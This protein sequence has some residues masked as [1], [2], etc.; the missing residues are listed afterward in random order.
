MAFAKPVPV[1]TSTAAALF[2]SIEVPFWFLALKPTMAHLATVPA[3]TLRYFF[4]FFDSHGFANF[5]PLP[6]IGV[7]V[8]SGLRTCC[9]ID[10]YRLQNRRP[11][12]ESAFASVVKIPSYMQPW[13]ILEKD[14]P[15]AMLHAKFWDK[16][17]VVEEQRWL[18]AQQASPA[19]GSEYGLRD[20]EGEERMDAVDNETMDEATTMDPEDDIISGCYMLDIDI[21][22]LEL[23]SLWIRAEYIRVFN[24]VNAY[25]D[26]PTS[27]RRAPCVVVTGQ[28]GIG[29]SVWVY[30]ALRRCLAERKPVIWYYQKHCYLFVE[31]G[32]YVMPDHFQKAHF[33]RFIWT[34]V[35]SDEAKE[36]VPEY[37]VPHGTRLF[38]IY[39]TSPRRDR[40]SRLHKTVRPIV[41][42][43]NPW[44]RKEILRVASTYTLDGINESRTNEIFDQ[45]GP[46][47]RLCIDYQ[48][49]SM[50]M[51]QYEQDLRTAM[52][53][54]ITTD[55]LE[56]LAWSL[57]SLLTSNQDSP[58]ER[59]EHLRLYKGFAV[60]ERIAGVF[61]EAVAQTAL[62]EGITLELVPVIKSDEARHEF[63]TV[64]N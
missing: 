24:L 30:Y 41:A 40:W 49:D 44:E 25:Y 57:P 52:I 42:I 28:P 3:S 39:S 33:K 62:Q 1:A 37:L 20:Q 6:T 53:S 14:E 47:P 58:M 26:K 5:L 56:S 7:C 29:K 13:P 21:D 2:L 23:T 18:K 9:A 22:E 48:L 17:M 60:R 59:K 54:V 46:T 51:R 61:F 63:L 11:V 19:T 36:G 43:M 8:E 35:D 45:L 50:A 16:S 55:K 32:V 27:V 31:E 4:L 64:R 15:F 38:V 34:L 10:T 12:S